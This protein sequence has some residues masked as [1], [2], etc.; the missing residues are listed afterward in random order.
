MRAGGCF[1]ESV[2]GD[3][4][5]WGRSCGASPCAQVRR[6]REP[7]DDQRPV[8]PQMV[9]A[10]RRQRLADVLPRCLD[11]VGHRDEHP[12]GGCGPALNATGLI[13]RSGLTHMTGTGGPDVIRAS[14]P[15]TS[16]VQWRTKQGPSLGWRS[17]LTGVDRQVSAS[18]FTPRVARHRFNSRSR[19]PRARRRRC[20]RCYAAQRA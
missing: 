18:R 19:R 5:P 14:P 9:L 17:G 3:Y 2:L 4:L 6:G 12:R 8:L 16:A 1:P 11:S 10:P 7:G 15:Q 20:P 13:H